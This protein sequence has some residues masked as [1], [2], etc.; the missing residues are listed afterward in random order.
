MYMP[1]QYGA[2]YGEQKGRLLMSQ[3]SKVSLWFMLR[4]G[5]ILPWLLFALVSCV[6]STLSNMISLALTAVLLFAAF[7][8][9]VQSLRSGS[10]MFT[11]VA[12][13]VAVAV[14][15]GYIWG[16]YV[17]QRFM[18]PFQD[19]SNLNTYPNVHPS[20]YNGQQLMDAGEIEF[21]A[22]SHLDLAKS[23]GFKNED[24]YCVAPVVGPDQKAGNGTKLATY[25]FWAV[26]TNCCSGHTP[27]YHCGEFSNPRARKGLRL[28]RDDERNFFRLAVEEAK[29]AYNIEANH[30]V[31]M[32]WMENPS[33]EVKQY[34]EDGYS[35]FYLGLLAFALVQLCVVILSAICLG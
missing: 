4:F 29:A 5:F 13:N 30:P 18:K 3:G 33:I 12:L 15:V 35:R 25:D 26:G 31:F 27:D 11:I 22:G 34:Q 2:I 1:Q 17:H 8:W 16:D 9:V 7:A 20:L 10:G 23:Y 21:I 28:M 6:V 19:I 14:A 24:I 32:Y